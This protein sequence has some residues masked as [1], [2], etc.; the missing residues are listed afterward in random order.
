ME[1]NHDGTRDRAT[2]KILNM[3]QIMFDQSLFF[4]VSFC[5]KHALGTYTM[6][7]MN[8]GL[9]LE[10]VQNLA[11]EMEIQC[12]AGLSCTSGVRNEPVNCENL[13]AQ[14]N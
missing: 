7:S 11:R 1:G 3:F 10:G 4:L 9:Y 14:K 5:S 2:N 12:N 13:V 8:T 6:I